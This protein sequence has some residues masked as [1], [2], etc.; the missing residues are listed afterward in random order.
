MKNETVTLKNLEELQRI[1]KKL[2]DKYHHILEYIGKLERT[3]ESLKG[4]I[5]DSERL[6]MAKNKARQLMPCYLLKATG[7]LVSLVLINRLI[8]ISIGFY[9]LFCVGTIYISKILFK[10]ILP[11]IKYI[12]YV[13]INDQENKIKACEAKIVIENKKLDKLKLKKSKYETSLAHNY[14]N[15]SIITKELDNLN[16][17]EDNAIINLYSDGHQYLKK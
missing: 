16:I 3:I 8:N 9:A 13:N 1:Q 10:D 12:T 11:N 17:N 14:K 5:T 4:M 15:I 7:I 6:I 2:E